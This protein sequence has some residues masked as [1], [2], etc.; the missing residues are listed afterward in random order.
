MRNL[1]R[2]LRVHCGPIQVPFGVNVKPVPR[3]PTNTVEATDGIGRFEQVPEVLAELEHGQI[4]FTLHVDVYVAGG[5]A[6]ERGG[7]IHQPPSLP[8]CPHD[9]I[10]IA[11][12]H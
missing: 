9:P 2:R 11:A 8:D 3:G 12:V 1:Q 10:T 6:G 7:G 5:I 4:G